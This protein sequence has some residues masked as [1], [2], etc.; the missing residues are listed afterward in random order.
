MMADEIRDGGKL[1][2]VATPIGNLEDITLRALRVLKE[3]DLIAAEDTR[4]SQ[5]LLEHFEIKKRL[6][7][8]HQFNEAK[9]TAEFLEKLKN[10]MSIALISDAGMPGISDPGERLISACAREEI[11]LEVIPG[12]SAVLQALVAAGFSMTPFHFGGFLPVKSSGR[13]RELVEARERSCTSIYFESPHRFLRCLQDAHAVM[14]E[15]CLCVARE[16]TKKFEEVKRGVATNL[17]KHFEGRTVKGEI[18][19]VIEGLKKS[20]ASQKHNKKDNEMHESCK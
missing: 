9:R 8:Y 7:S 12:P 10:G 15:R 17:L 6:V 5:H 18:C 2:V 20:E 13:Q 4:H 16:L 3:V 1:Y 14:P 19:I 11:P